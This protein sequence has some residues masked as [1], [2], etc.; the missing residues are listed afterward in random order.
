M[1][2]GAQVIR[3]EAIIMQL[4]HAVLGLSPAVPS[5]RPAPEAHR[6]QVSEAEIV[7][8]IAVAG[9]TTSLATII[10]EHAFTTAN[11]ALAGVRYLCQGEA[12]RDAY[13]RMTPAEFTRINARQAWANWRTIPR[14]LRGQ[15]PTDRPLT[16]LDLCCGTG[17][18]THVLAWW[19][20]S[21]SQIVGMELDPRFAASASAQTYRNRHG[22][23]IPVTVRRASIL[24]GFCDHTGARQADGSVDVVHAIGSIGCHFTPDQ[25]AIIVDECAR[26]LKRDGMALLDTG[27]AGTSEQDLTA[28]A[29]QRAFQVVGRS[30]SWWLDR[31]VQLVLRRA[32]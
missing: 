28:I 2:A 27:S 8:A 22:E 26:V 6:L 25:A 13:R 24:D 30:K 17:D 5:R 18:S 11:L 1:L 32:A 29:N 4:T 16:V 3:T 10:A 9:P 7:Q 15:L 19:L 12:A 21:G 23:I 14:N 31:Y 20:P